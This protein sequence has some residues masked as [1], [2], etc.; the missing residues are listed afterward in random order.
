[1]PLIS[2]VSSCLV[3][4]PLD[5]PTTF[6]TRTVHAREYLL[7]RV[8]GDDGVTGAGFCYPGNHS[9]VLALEAVRQ[10]LARVII[11]RDAHATLENW[12][13][14]H[15][16]ALLHGRAGVVTRAISALDIAL[17]D[18]NARA[19]KLPLHKFLG[20]Y[21]SRIPA[22]ASGGYYL[23]GKTP[24]DLGRELAGYVALGFKAVKMKVGLLDV[25]DE[26]AR[27]AA[28]RAAI[29][30]DVLLM[31]DASNSWT[32]VATA[33]RF[34]RLAYEPFEPYWIEEPFA[35]DDVLNHARLARR[36]RIPVATGEIE[37]GR[38]RFLALMQAEACAILQPDAQV[39][40]GI[41]EYRRIA[42]TA[43][44]FGLPVCP[45]AFHDLHKHLVAASANAPFAEVFT[46]AS[47]LNFTALIDRQ[48]EL[49]D[50]EI[51]LGDEPGLGFDFDDGVVARYAV[52]PWSAIAQ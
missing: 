2:S 25:A 12:Q 22:Y 49:R 11:G 51:M 48:S 32:D 41:T 17:W 20:S 40:G 4:V 35:P 24:E 23:K 16:E 31:L 3:R 39:C 47:I 29:G 45:H 30:P 33:D 15:Q 34:M 1:M 6:A 19:A 26:R 18:R 8:T 10:M 42:A 9:A 38:T 36:T 7:V 44:S 52:E 14:M 43:E 46:D 28:A 27:M 5:R 50:G 13:C 37:A 21:R